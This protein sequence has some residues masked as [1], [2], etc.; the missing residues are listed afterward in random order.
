MAEQSQNTVLTTENIAQTTPE[1]Q[2]Q[3]E[4]QEPQTK[5][6]YLNSQTVNVRSAAS[7]EASVVTQQLFQNKMVGQKLHLMEEM[8]T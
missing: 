1:T 8:D 5:T 7:Q 4:T 6:M 3:P 2:E